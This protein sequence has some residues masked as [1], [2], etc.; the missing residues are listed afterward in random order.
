MPGGDK[1]AYYPAR[2]LLGALVKTSGVED[3]LSLFLKRGYHELLPGG[4]VEAKLAARQA[5][6]SPRTSSA[7]RFLDAVA[8]ALRVAYER[9]YEGEPAIVLEEYSWGGSFV[10]LPLEVE[11]GRVLTGE[12]LLK[13]VGG[14]LSSVHPRDLARSVQQSLGRCLGLIAKEQ[15][16]T[17]VVVSGGAAVNSY[18]VKGLRDV[19]G[20]DNVLVPRKLPPGDGGISSG[21]IFYSILSNH[22]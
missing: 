17:R 1:A 7:G 4:L 14:E 9:S 15:G 11:N 19:L 10:E 5:E 8:A 13:L 21:Q 20:R 2:M 16:A 18:I 12:F 3:G 22:I 6:N